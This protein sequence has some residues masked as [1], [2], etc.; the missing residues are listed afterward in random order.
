[1][2]TVGEPLWAMCAHTHSLGEHVSTE[3]Q[4]QKLIPGGKEQKEPR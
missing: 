2:N 3:W 4:R 1:M